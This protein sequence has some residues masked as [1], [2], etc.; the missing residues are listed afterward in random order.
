MTFEVQSI[1]YRS[2][3]HPTND[4]QSDQLAGE[5]NGHESKRVVPVQ[6]YLQAS[7]GTEARPGGAP[8][9]MNPHLR[10]E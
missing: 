2:S 1:F 7:E 5:A 3:E 9:L 10:P 4:L 8:M 6:M